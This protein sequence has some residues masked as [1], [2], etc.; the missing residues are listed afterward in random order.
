MEGERWSGGRIDGERERVH[1]SGKGGGEPRQRRVEGGAMPNQ[2]SLAR[3][4]REDGAAAPTLVG[5][6]SPEIH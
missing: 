6:V 1:A 3:G 5:S 2:S 4:E